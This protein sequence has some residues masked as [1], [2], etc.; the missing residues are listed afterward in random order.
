MTGIKMEASKNIA[1]VVV[2]VVVVV[3]MLLF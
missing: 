3:I 1:V 2:V